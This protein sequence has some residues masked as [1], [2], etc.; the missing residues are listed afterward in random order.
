M[1]S[2]EWRDRSERGIILIS[3]IIIIRGARIKE[4]VDSQ[5]GITEVRM[6]SNDLVRLSQLIILVQNF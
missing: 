5:R 2:D 1:F 3:N 4:V 6:L